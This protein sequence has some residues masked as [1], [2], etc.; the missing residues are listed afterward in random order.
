MGDHVDAG[1]E[2]SP[3]ERLARIALGRSRPAAE[4]IVRCAREVPPGFA[5]RAAVLS[6]RQGRRRVST[7]LLAVL[8]TIDS[9]LFAEVF[10]AAVCPG[11]AGAVRQF[12]WWVRSGI[13]GRRS[14]GTRPKKSLQDWLNAT[15]PGI[16]RAEAFA[17]E[18]R[19]ADIVA[20][21]HPKA[22]GPEHALIYAW[23]TGRPAD[24]SRLPLPLPAEEGARDPLLLFPGAPAD[25]VRAVR[26]D[27]D[28][29][30]GDG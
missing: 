7:L 23:M 20:W 22:P 6:A 24:A 11:D 3:E 21:T 25:A 1:P 26:L 15:P 2:R 8:S 29:E 5:A 10:P 12:A 9:G 17:G 27:S 16:L 19:L 13:A 14:F 18:P 4:D 30:H 28:R